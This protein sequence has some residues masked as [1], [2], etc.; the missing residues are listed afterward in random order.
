MSVC[1]PMSSVAVRSGVREPATW[2]TWRWLLV[3][4]VAAAV[5]LRF[6][7]LLQQSVWYDEVL[8]HDLAVQSF[9]DML[10]GVA[11]T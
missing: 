5:A 2:P 10:S 3:G 8:T 4:I 9:G 1:G 7:L 6:G 11:N